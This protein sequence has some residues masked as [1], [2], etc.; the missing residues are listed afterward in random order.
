[1]NSRAR[2]H[3]GFSMVEV[4]VALIIMSVGLLG[5]AK[6]QALALSST[7][8]ARMRS[9]AALEAASLASTMRADRGYWTAVTSPSTVSIVNGVIKQSTDPLLM[10]P[11]GTAFQSC[12]TSG[13]PCTSVQIAATDLEEWIAGVTAVL[14]NST[15]TITC[16]SAP[17]NTPIGCQVV[18]SWNENQVA[19]NSQSLPTGVTP[20]TY[21]LYVNP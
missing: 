7:G 20:T 10:Q 21:T 6:M 16:N 15:E 9:L 11:P 1:M 3:A 4:M 18:L 13:S 5:V 19:I 17:A 8:S 12:V 14:P 2:A